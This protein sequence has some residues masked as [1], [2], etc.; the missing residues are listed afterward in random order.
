MNYLLLPDGNRLNVGDVVTLSRFPGT[1][2]ILQN[3]W[4]FYEGRQQNG[5]YFSSIPADTVIPVNDS[6]LL[7][8]T[9]VATNNTHNCPPFYPGGGP[10]CHPHH[11][12][13]HPQ[14]FPPHPPKPD[15]GNGI[16]DK[17]MITVDTIAE[18]NKLITNTLQNGRIVRVNDVQ[19]SVRYF[20][21]DALN[22]T[23]KDATLTADMIKT[24]DTFAEDTLVK[25]S[26]EWEDSDD[27]LP[28]SKAVTERIKVVS[29]P[30]W[31]SIQ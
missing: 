9:I 4:Y 27:Q 16:I 19:G 6:D 2:W 29:G 24:L 14:P 18:R 13:H 28:T 11:P 1:K 30:V 25:S 17:T 7:T 31:E 26:Q 5:W 12:P 15:K 20:E 22:L 21:W 8:L 10:D 3:G 23:W